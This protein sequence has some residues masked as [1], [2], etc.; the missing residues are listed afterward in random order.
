M[1]LIEIKKCWGEPRGLLWFGHYRGSV[2]PKYN[3]D[4][5]MVCCWLHPRADFVAE[6]ALPLPRRL[7]VV[8]RLGCQSFLQR[9]PEKPAKL[10][11]GTQV[12]QTEF[13]PLDLW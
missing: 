13:G 11:T 2:I 6:A 7:L 12:V 4:H 10:K 3:S 5:S 1:P 8:W 9:E